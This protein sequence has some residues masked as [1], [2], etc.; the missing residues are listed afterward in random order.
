MERRMVWTYTG[1]KF[2]SH[3]QRGKHA[4]HYAKQ[5]IALTMYLQF[6]ILIQAIHLEML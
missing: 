4:D 3:G 2:E 6:S 1:L 5:K